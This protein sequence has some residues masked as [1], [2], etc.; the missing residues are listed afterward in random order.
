MRVYVIKIHR[1]L[2]AFFFA[3]PNGHST[4]HLTELSAQSEISLRLNNFF[5]F[6]VLLYSN[7]L[8]SIMSLK[9]LLKMISNQFLKSILTPFLYREYK[10]QLFFR[11]NERTIEYRF[12]LD[13]LTKICP[14]TV[15]DVGSGTT[16]LPQIIRKCGFIVTA[17]D[18]IKDYWKESIF[19]RHYYVIDDDILNTKLDK[20]F[21]FITCISV[22]EH[23]VDHSKAVRSMSSLLNPGGYLILTFP[24]NEK[25]YLEDVY[26]LP[27]VNL[28]DSIN[29]LCQVYSRKEVDRWTKEN[30]LII[31]EQEYWQFYEGI[32]WDFGKQLEPPKEVM[33]SDLHQLTCIIFKKI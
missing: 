29:F 25:E 22:L 1:G 7:L 6:I 2:A 15:L 5:R 16:P 14:L 3:K 24:Y 26:K 32:Y 27:G 10:T 28:D 4:L 23:I 20:K 33:V 19:N 13:Q 21:D 17:I 30:N 12:L 18:N 11:R 31:V 9:K 8:K